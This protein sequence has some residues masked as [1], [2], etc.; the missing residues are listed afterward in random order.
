MKKTLFI[1]LLLAAAFSMQSCSTRRAAINDLEALVERVEKNG[2]GYTLA[3]WENVIYRCA[4]IE[5]KLLKH[6]YTTEEH[7]EIGTLKG[8]LAGVVTKDI[9]TNSAKMVI[10]IKEQLGG[11]AEGFLDVFME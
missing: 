4:E 8:R 5:K 6:E 7:R 3:D 1:C 9:L 2:E 11:G 10:N